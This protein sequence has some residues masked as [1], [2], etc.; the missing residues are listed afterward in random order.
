LFITYDEISKEDKIYYE[1]LI[2]KVWR[3]PFITE[4]KNKSFKYFNNTMSQ[5]A[6]ARKQVELLEQAYFYFAPTMPSGDMWT[7]RQDEKFFD[8]VR[9]STIPFFICEKNANKNGMEH[10]G[11]KTYSGFNLDN[12]AL[13]NPVERWVKTLEDNKEIFTDLK[14]S[15][16]VYDQNKDVIKFNLDHFMNTNWLNY[17]QQQFDALPNSIQNVLEKN[18]NV[19]KKACTK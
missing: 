9:C 15:K 18:F 5:F 6:F 13:V 3:D 12:E 2:S 11:F 19:L 8:A 14:I 1:H 4:F 10:L 7:Q 16:E 17:F